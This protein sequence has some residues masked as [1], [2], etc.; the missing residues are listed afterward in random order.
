MAFAASVALREPLNAL[1]AATIFI[2]FPPCKYYLIH[3]SV[4][5]K[6]NPSILPPIIS[7]EAVA[8]SK[9]G[10]IFDIIL[11]NSEPLTY[12]KI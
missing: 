11:I 1:G 10:V 8:V 7:S 6:K 3:F 9:N 12:L 5:C 2:G 4:H